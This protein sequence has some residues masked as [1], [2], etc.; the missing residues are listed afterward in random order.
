VNRRSLL[1]AGGVALPGLLS[2][3][4]GSVGLPTSERRLHTVSLD[5]ASQP[6]SPN[7]AFDA[8][9]EDNTITTGSTAQI[10]LEYTNTSEG[11]IS[12]GTASWETFASTRPRPRALLVP[13]G[14]DLT[15]RAKD[16]WQPRETVTYLLIAPATELDPGATFTNTYELWGHDKESGSQAC[17]QRTTY[18][19]ELPE[20]VRL[21]VSVMA[22]D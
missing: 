6:P 18:E 16:C 4:L 10:Q 12:L 19:F 7:L 21:A 3:C 9:V 8:S 22:P 2:G 14:N 13:T 5:T 15:R 1:A 11:P 20:G 17:I